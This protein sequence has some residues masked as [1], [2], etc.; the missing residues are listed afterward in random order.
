MLLSELDSMRLYAP[1]WVVATVSQI[2]CHCK[3]CP[4]PKLIPMRGESHITFDACKAA[5]IL[6]SDTHVQSFLHGFNMGKGAVFLDTIGLTILGPAF[7]L[8]QDRTPVQSWR[9]AAY[10][11]YGRDGF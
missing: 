9:Y 11:R 2:I 10:L 1:V 6:C 7:L 5:L 8:G 4:A 3:R